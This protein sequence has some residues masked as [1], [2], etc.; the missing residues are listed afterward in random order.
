[1][2][3]TDLATADAT[4]LATALDN[5][6]AALTK[7]ADE[8]EQASYRIAA[9]LESVASAIAF[10]NFEQL[11]QAI[12]AQAEATDLLASYTYDL[13]TGIGD[14]IGEALH[15]IGRVLNEYQCGNPGNYKQQIYDLPHSR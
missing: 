3:A 8:T 9:G 2:Q 6:A 7:Q 14:T 13:N 4:L 15:A 1:M 12:Q 5:I 11:P 10:A